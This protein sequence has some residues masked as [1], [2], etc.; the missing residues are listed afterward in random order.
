M[1]LWANVRNGSWSNAG[2]NQPNEGLMETGSLV[3]RQ[4]H[5]TFNPADLGSNPRRPTNLPE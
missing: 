2:S 1:G 4:E 3:Q 5:G